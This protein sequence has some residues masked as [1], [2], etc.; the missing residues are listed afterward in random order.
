M[1]FEIGQVTLTRNKDPKSGFGEFFGCLRLVLIVNPINRDPFAGE[2]H[3]S[4]MF[5]VAWRAP[6]SP[7]INKRYLA[8]E[9]SAIKSLVPDTDSGKLENWGGVIY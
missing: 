4:W 1:L 2:L 7:N 6:G 9:L 3:V 5:Y 8:C